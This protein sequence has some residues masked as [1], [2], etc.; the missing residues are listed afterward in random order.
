MEIVLTLAGKK[1][2]VASGDFQAKLR[3]VEDLGLEDTAWVIEGTT[4]EIKALIPAKGSSSGRGKGTTRAPSLQTWTSL[5]EEKRAE[6]ASAFKKLKGKKE[7]SE[8]LKEN[9]VDGRGG[10][11]LEEAANA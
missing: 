11:A 4:E 9:D 10:R 3:A 6:L 5:N 8:F 2:K 1:H 7:P